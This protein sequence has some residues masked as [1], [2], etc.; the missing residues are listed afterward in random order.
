MTN[1]EYLMNRKDEAEQKALEMLK[2]N[3]LA[4]SQFYMNGAKGFE[5]RAK[6]LT[7]EEASKRFI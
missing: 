3:E 6:A 7:V 1:Y 5:K 4:L 2:K